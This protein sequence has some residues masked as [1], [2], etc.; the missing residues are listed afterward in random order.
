MK[1]KF[2]SVDVTPQPS[3]PKR[4]WL[5]YRVNGVTIGCAMTFMCNG[6]FNVGRLGRTFDW[7]HTG[8]EKLLG[9]EKYNA[10]RDRFISP[11]A[12][13]VYGT[14]ATIPLKRVKEIFTAVATA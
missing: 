6:R 12:D 14:G 13:L 7:N 3:L 4:K 11:R 1:I 9:T 5:E 8:L 2:T 10:N